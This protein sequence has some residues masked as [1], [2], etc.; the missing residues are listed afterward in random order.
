M[1]ILTQ[2]K[3]T[4]YNFNHLKIHPFAWAHFGTKK[5]KNMFTEEINKIA[6]TSNDDKRS[7]SFDK[8]T[9]YFYEYL[10]IFHII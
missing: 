4:N 1:I 7:Q 2:C 10:N 5:R 8:F 9:S 6:L 3:V